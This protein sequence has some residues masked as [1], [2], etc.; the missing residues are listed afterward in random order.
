MRLETALTKELG[1]RW[2]RINSDYEK[3]LNDGVDPIALERVIENSYQVGIIIDKLNN[4]RIH[5]ILEG[6]QDE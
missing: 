2:I 1:V 3:L 6:K 4:L 5:D